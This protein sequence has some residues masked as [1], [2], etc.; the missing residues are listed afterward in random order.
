MARTPLQTHPRLLL[1]AVIGASSA[2]LIPA[3]AGF[4]VRVIGSWDV[5]ASL[6]LALCWTM[7]LRPDTGELQRRAQIQDEDESAFTIL[8]VTAAIASI[9][10]L[11]SLGLLSGFKNLPPQQQP[12]VLGLASYTILC[13]WSFLHTLFTVHYAHEYYGDRDETDP[14]YQGPQGGLQFAGNPETPTYL[15]FAYFSFT[16][17]MTAQTS[18]TGITSSPMRALTLIHGV[19]SFVFNTVIL[20]LTVNIAASLL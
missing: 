1:G 4:L 14:G 11:A 6:Y 9:S 10:L 17:G 18:D 8:I 7:M 15:D 12:F 3:S 5:G 2:W 19:L 16:I 13:S 20:A